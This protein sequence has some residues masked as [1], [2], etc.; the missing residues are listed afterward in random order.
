[1]DDPLQ[2]CRYDGG[3]DSFAGYVRDCD[4][5]AVFK[6]HGIVEVSADGKTRNALRLK[7]CI[8]EVGSEMAISPP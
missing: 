6:H 7:F 8:G 3:R 5:D 2:R 1:M 4:A